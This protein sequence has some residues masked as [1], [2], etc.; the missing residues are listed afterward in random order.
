GKSFIRNSNAAKLSNAKV[1]LYYLILGVGSLFARLPLQVFYP[2]S[3]LLSWLAGFVFRY[4]RDVVL[5]NL[6]KA[7]PEKTDA[8]REVIARKFYLHFCDTIVEI[9][10]QISLNKNLIPPR[11]TIEN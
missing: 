5:S 3:T 6:K 9:F 7:F 10:K 4:R 1:I 2:L 11:V 8:E